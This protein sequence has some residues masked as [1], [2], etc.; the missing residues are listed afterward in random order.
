MLPS[1]PPLALHVAMQ[2]P[3]NGPHIS[4]VKITGQGL[5]SVAILVALLWT[6]LIGERIVFGRAADDAAQVMRAMR[7]LR[8]KT[9]REPAAAPARSPHARLHIKLG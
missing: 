5:V 7:E 9:R 4:V 1:G 3:R 8:L 2:V 6:C